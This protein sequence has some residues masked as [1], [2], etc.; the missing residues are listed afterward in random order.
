VTETGARTELFLAPLSRPVTLLTRALVLEIEEGPQRGKKFGPI[1]PPIRLGAATANEVVLDDPTVSRF[2][3]TIDVDGDT[4]L[5]TDTGST[6]GTFVGGQRVKIGYLAD[7]T[8]IRLGQ[9][10]IAIK[11]EA[12]SAVE[13]SS[14]ASFGDLA[15][16][17]GVMRALF[18][19]L[20]RLAKTAAPVLIEG[21]TGS[22]KELV[23]RALHTEGPR[24]DRPFVVVDCGAIA[25]T[26]IE[27]ELFGHERGAF[28]GAD[29]KR[30]GAFARA[31]AGTVF[32]DEIGELPLALQPKLLRV[33][34][35]GTFKP[36]GSSVEA[37]TH[38]RVI[39]ATHRDLRRLVNE[40]RFRED[41]YFRLAVVPVR[42]PPLR[43]RGD[44]L[45]LLA[46]RFFAR[47]YLAA[48]G[49]E[50]IPPLSPSTVGTIKAHEW[51]GNVRELKN[52]IERAMALLEPEL[53]NT[54]ALETALR[55]Q[56][57]G[58]A[59][60][61]IDALPLDEAK[62]SFERQYLLALLARFGEDI[63]GAAAS[64]EIHPKSLARLLRRHRLRKIDLGE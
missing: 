43:T 25:P 16:K 28:T 23:A 2:H 50:P 56:E 14:E 57:T 10:I 26:L 55:P 52:A 4:A 48:G 3:A 20:G 5:I 59:P 38:A 39:S 37:T 34:E 30:D 1:A 8:R 24:K 18:S 62:R 63:E 17:S 64:A 33:L 35:S 44:D 46:E 41:L 27:S 45:L 6:N 9:T 32:L 53:A 21:E 61:R 11:T 7:G 12:P 29:S 22:G 49:A 13:L 15:G 36:L 60:G 19:V 31:G 42:V 40:T 51:P 58:A 47:A 54:G